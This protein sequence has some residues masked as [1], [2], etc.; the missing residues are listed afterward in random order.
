MITPSFPLTATERVL[1][2]LTLDFTTGVLDSRVSVTRALN[3]ATRVNSSGYIELVNADL[4]RFDYDPVTLAPKGLLIE[5]QRTNVFT[6]SSDLTNSEWIKGGTSVA[7]DSTTSPDGTLNADKLV[8]DTATSGHGITVLTPPASGTAYAFSF[9]AKQ[10][11]RSR[12]SF[13]G[14]GFAAQG[15]SAIFDIANGTMAVNNG[16]KGSITAVGNGWYR[17]V[18]AFTTSNTVQFGLAMANNS[19]A[20]NYTGDGTSGVFIWGL[21]IEVGA[22]PTSYI[23]TNGSSLTRN[24][25][26]VDMTGTNFSDWYNVSE[27]TF[28][29]EGSTSTGGYLFSGMGTA[30]IIAFQ[31]ASTVVNFDAYGTPFSLLAQQGNA[32]GTINKIAGAYA[33]NNYGLSVNGASAVTDTSAAVP[34]LNALRIGYGYAAFGWANGHIRAIRYYP[35]R[36]T[37]RELQALTA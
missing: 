32:L 37:N 35:I 34:T 1:P 33:V 5:E 4:P 26:S 36:L 19:N 9:Y 15:F 21:Q 6:Y 14:G 29:A 23:P 7:N 3:T 17:C 24:A 10:D 30:P 11:G 2:R 27:G 8:E 13:S 16:G 12:I 18:I 22:S 31:N 20:T 28:F 25:D